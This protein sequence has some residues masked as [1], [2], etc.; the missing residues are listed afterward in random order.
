MVMAR[1]PSWRMKCSGTWWSLSMVAILGVKGW[2]GDIGTVVA[3]MMSLTQDWI[4]NW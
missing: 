2:E 3:F 4:T 1:E